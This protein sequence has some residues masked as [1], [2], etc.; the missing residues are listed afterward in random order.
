MDKVPVTP[1]ALIQRI[2]R[3]LQPEQR[4]TACRRSSRAWHEL[5]DY[6]CIDVFRNVITHKHVDPE[7]FG[8]E[9]GAL[10]SFEQVLP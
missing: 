7:T 2:N 5:G 8:R 9:I 6:Y 3:K 1:R 10:Q 4:L